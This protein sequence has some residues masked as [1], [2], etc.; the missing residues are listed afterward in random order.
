MQVVE[1]FFAS[2]WAFTWRLVEL[3]VCLWII[4]AALRSLFGGF[5]R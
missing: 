1:F 5:R 3:V 2:L 4:V